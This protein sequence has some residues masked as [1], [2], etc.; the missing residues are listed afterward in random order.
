MA[1]FTVSIVTESLEP[2]FFGFLEDDAEV[3]E[4]VFDGSSTELEGLEVVSLPDSDTL[5]IQPLAM[6][7][8]LLA[9]ANAKR[10]NAVEVKDFRPISLV[11]SVYKILAEVLANRLSS[12]LSTII[13][14]SQNAFVQG[15]QITDSVLVANK[16]LDSRLKEGVP[17]VI[18][19]LDVEKA[20]DH[21]NWNFLLNLLERCGF[22]LKWRKWIHYCISTGR[23]SIL[24]N[25]S[26]EGLFGSSH[27]IRQGDSLSPLLF[28]IVM[29]ALSRM[30]NRVVEN[31]LLSDF[32]VGSRD[33]HWVHVSHLLFADDTLIFS[34]ANPEHIFNLRLLFTWFEAISGLRI[35]FNKSEM[36]PVGNVVNMAGLAAI[37]GVRL[38][39]SL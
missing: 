9:D 21:V 34:D 1:P 33:T 2:P 25:G 4:G 23:F 7:S 12:V 3:V 29:E 6:I 16:Y 10:A 24:I 14:P 31:G 36:V 35:N 19:K 30:M 8:P 39:L 22:C 27:S 13:S 32:K 11:G 17:E 15:H 5:V 18:C 26:P 38:F 37:M 28:A 20:Y